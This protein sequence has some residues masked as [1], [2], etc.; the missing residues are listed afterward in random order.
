[1]KSVLVRS[2]S[3]MVPS[4]QQR[5]AR[6]FLLGL[7]TDELQCIAE[8]LGSCI[9]ESERLRGSGRAD[10]NDCVQR[11]YNCRNCSEPERSHKAILLVEFLRRYGIGSDSLAT[12]AEQG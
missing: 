9:L 12:P 2:L 10:L 11:F 7:S 4:G 6:Q 5:K 8:F 1:M 3:S